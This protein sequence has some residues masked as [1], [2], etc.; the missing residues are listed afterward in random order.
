M[1]SLLVETSRVRALRHATN[2]VRATALALLGASLLLAGA[3]LLLRGIAYGWPTARF[4]R[5]SSGHLCDNPAFA[6][7]FFPGPWLPETAPVRVT[8]SPLADTLRVVVLGESAAYGYP[9]PAFGLARMLE[10]LLENGSGGR[11]VEVI[12]AALSGVS[13]PVLREVLRDSLKLRPDV[14]LLYLGNNEFI[15]PFGAGNPAVAALPSPLLVRAQVLASRLRLTQWVRSHAPSTLAAAE[16]SPM[17]CQLMQPGAPAVLETHVRFEANLNAMLDDAKAAG[18]PVVL[19][20]VPVNTRDWAPF[21][22]LHRTNLDGAGLDAWHAAWQ[23]GMARWDEND[24]AAALAAWQRAA[25]LDPTPARLHYMMG[26]ALQ[27]LGDTQAAEAAFRSALENDAM[28]YRVTPAMNER[29]R[30]VATSHAGL[31]VA[32]ADCDVAINA[33]GEMFYDHCHLTPAG[34]YAVAGVMLQAMLELAIRGIEQPSFQ[35]SDAMTRLGL[36]SWHAR[37][38]IKYVRYLAERPP[39]PERVE[40]EAWLVRMDAEIKKLD[41]QLAGG[42]L[43]QARGDVARAIETHPYDVWLLRNAAQLDLASGNPAA[44]KD[45]LTRLLELSPIFT[46]AWPLLARAH[47][48][49]AAPPLAA[50]AWRK[51]CG[52][53]PDRRD[54]Q[55][56]LATTLF[57]AKDYAAARAEYLA[58]AEALPTDA[59]A[60]WKVG[61]T[62]EREEDFP[63]AI[64][65]YRRGLSHVPEHAGL[66]YY[67]AKALLH[68][69]ERDEARSLA[70]QGL[71]L[72]PNN[73]GL[74]ELL[75]SM[76]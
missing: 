74:E 70:E 19:C 72:D 18:V 57:D 22:S 31:G 61:Q 62:F 54:W 28:P 60:W 38:N 64:A 45:K 51:A 35:P 73:K 13:T 63:A 59:D 20:T 32:L 29:I 55:L 10:V 68:E 33:T 50:E 30:H 27:S 25:E 34:N 66:H 69:G 11:K 8:P 41:A 47:A 16:V 71:K 12:N 21:G 39:Y 14:V 44:A 1:A 17:A 65:T 76:R 56:A 15:G 2:L 42:E 23:E 36:N 7:R 9:D 46:P 43:E 5:D 53:R 37:E 58:L 24:A 6:R 48:D 3:E 4:V 26:R 67:L 52:L 40:H 75:E 49:T